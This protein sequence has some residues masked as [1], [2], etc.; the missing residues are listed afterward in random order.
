MCSPTSSKARSTAAATIGA[1]S[2]DVLGP[3]AI[4]KPILVW[5]AQICLCDRPM[6][7]ILTNVRLPAAGECLD[8]A[9][10]G[11]ETSGNKSLAVLCGGEPDPESPGLRAQ[12]Q[13][14]IFARSRAVQLIAV[15]SRA[16]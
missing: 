3:L 5:P 7:Q 16:V 14:L 11:S 9:C 4:R 6:R 13:P 15:R 8:M 12:D 1:V 10:Y 2:H